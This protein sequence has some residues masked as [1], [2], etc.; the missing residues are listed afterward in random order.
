MT[1]DERPLTEAAVIAGA[2]AAAPVVR[3]L[4]ALADAGGECL[5]VADRQGRIVFSNSSACARLGVEAHSD[6]LSLSDL[7]SAR[8]AAELTPSGAWQGAVQMTHRKSGAPVDLL[9]RAVSLTDADGN[10]DGHVYV[11]R[12]PDPEEAAESAVAR[13]ARRTQLVQ[14]AANFTFY[15]VNLATGLVERDGWVQQVLG[16]HPAELGTDR[17]GWLE[18][19]HPDDAEA[20]DRAYAAAVAG[21]D[22]LRI[23]YRVRNKAGDWVWVNDIALVARDASGVARHITG[24]VTDVSSRKASE[25]ALEE[26]TMLAAGVSEVAPS[27]LYIYDLE[28]TRNVWGNREITRVLGYSRAELDAIEGNLM[29]ALIHPDDWPGYQQH[30]ARIDALADGE[31]ARFDY[32]MRRNDGG[33]VW[34]SSIDMVFRRNA[35]GKPSQIVG[36]ALDITAARAM[37]HD[38]AES[39][40]AIERSL[41]ELELVYAR[42]PLG[43]A[44]IDTD[45]RIVRIN[46]ALAEINGF[47]VEE[48]IGRHV[49]DMVPDLREGIE[50]ILRRVIETG[51]AQLDVPIVGETPA[52]PGLSSSIRSPTTTAR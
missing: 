4:L 15:E 51:E 40:R 41:R 33:W 35:A 5:M 24:C 37:Q 19:I 49:W 39:R 46:Q 3:A 28:R 45:L 50:P 1:K 20:V 6:V 13:V 12:A 38:L 52:Q 42:A 21:L 31:R 43:L 30:L 10:P 27:I 25:A 36:S 2:G 7:V 8:T 44:L 14:R 18:I 29:Q 9:G 26:S 17:Q 32:R 11:L 48:H 47:A 34:L 23:D 16:Y 22:S